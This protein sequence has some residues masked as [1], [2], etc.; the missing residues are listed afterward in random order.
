MIT[1]T[2]L[3]LVI[4]AAATACKSVIP[5]SV[6]EESPP[7]ADMEINLMYADEPKD[8]AERAA[9]DA[10]S[11]SGLVVASARLSLDDE[12]PSGLKVVRVVENS[13]ADAAG[14]EPDDIVLVVVTADGEETEVAWPSEWRKLELDTPPGTEVTVLFDRA[15]IEREARF[16][17]IPRVRPAGREEIARYRE[18]QRVGVV[19]RTATEVEAR[20]AGLGPG[21]GAVVIGLSRASPWR[22]KGIRY[23]DLLVEIGGE[24]VAHPQVVLDA[25]RDGTGKLAIVYVRDG[26]RKKVEA[27]LTRREKETKG[28]YIPL[29]WDYERE[30]DRSE[31]SILLGLYGHTKTAVAARYRILWFITFSRGDA[32]RLVEEKNP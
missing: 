11:F 4:L 28:F 9:L 2:A 19:L 31:L 1:R 26:E 30:G 20:A 29:F 7:L 25:I 27:S 14:L 15:G 5:Q 22:K 8:E 3:A 32:D 17:M 10:G 6:P 16:T 12:E 18:N 24:A 13:P 21:A 23:G